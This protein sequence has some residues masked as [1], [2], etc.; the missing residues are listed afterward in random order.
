MSDG[1]KSIDQVYQ[2]LIMNGFGFYERMSS[3][4]DKPFTYVAKFLPLPFSKKN[5]SYSDGC[6]L[7]VGMPIAHSHHFAQK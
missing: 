5:N 7:R 3:S 2:N 6:T 4:L 1:V